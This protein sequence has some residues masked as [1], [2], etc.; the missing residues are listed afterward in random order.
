VALKTQGEMRIAYEILICKPERKTLLEKYKIVVYRRI[1][2]N[3]LEI[4]SV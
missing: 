1:I 2:L 3:V 4:N